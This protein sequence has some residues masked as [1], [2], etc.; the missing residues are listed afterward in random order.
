LAKQKLDDE[1]A[2]EERIQRQKD[3][4]EKER[5][6]EEAN[7]IAEKERIARQKQAEEDR[8]AREKQRVARQKQAEEDRKAR[9]AQLERDRIARLEN[10]TPVDLTNESSEV[11]FSLFLI[12]CSVICY[13]GFVVTFGVCWIIP[14]TVSIQLQTYKMQKDVWNEFIKSATKYELQI[15]GTFIFEVLAN[16]KQQTTTTT[17]QQTSHNSTTTT[18][19]V[20]I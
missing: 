16:N 17:T 1:R 7:K 6:K 15:S 11:L 3:R 14:L 4:E 20:C 18:A 10:M 13:L 19:N 5:R 8:I 2:E 12:S 9:Q